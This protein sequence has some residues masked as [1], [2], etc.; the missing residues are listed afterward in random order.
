[1]KA[2]F[3]Y[4]HNLPSNCREEIAQLTIGFIPDEA[5]VST[6]VACPCL[7]DRQTLLRP[8]FDALVFSRRHTC[9]PLRTQATKDLGVCNRSATTRS[10]VSPIHEFSLFI[11]PHLVHCNSVRTYEVL[12]A[13]GIPCALV[14]D[15]AVAY[16]M[17]KVDLVLVGS[18]AVVESGGLINAV[19]SYQM[20]IVAKAANK[21]V[22]ALAERYASTP[23]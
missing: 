12:R 14:L 20:S 3:A 1:M 21:P 13:A 18:E 9:S 22:Y 7:F 16:V 23:C 8:D 4:A 10:W 11:C 5:V 17:D 19:G 15:S 6:A 2:G